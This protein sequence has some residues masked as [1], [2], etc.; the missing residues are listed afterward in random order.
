MRWVSIDPATVSGVAVWQGTSVDRIL[1][2]TT[3]R[4]GGR[5]EANVGGVITTYATRWAMWRA[6]LD[7]ASLV[8]IEDGY[9]GGNRHSAMKSA[10][11][12]GVIRGFAE[13]VGAEVVSWLPSRWRAILAGPDG[14]KWPGQRERAKSR[15]FEA[16]RQM[17]QERYLPQQLPPLTE[18]EVEAVC[19]GAAYLVHIE[20][21]HL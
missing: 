13:S 7:G 8:V 12:R 19:I 18:D 10:E 2:A 11:V 15:A 9:V 16:V 1:R 14:Q 21:W 5:S 20:E 17:Q 3:P 6:I 4:H